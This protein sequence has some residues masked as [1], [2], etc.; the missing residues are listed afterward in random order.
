MYIYAH[1][2]VAYIIHTVCGDGHL[3]ELI[4]RNEDDG[5]FNLTWFTAKRWLPI[6]REQ[7]QED[8]NIIIVLYTTI[9]GAK[10]VDNF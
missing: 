9:C 6:R 1:T 8:N 10:S 2:L 5:S 7:T 4:A 3:C